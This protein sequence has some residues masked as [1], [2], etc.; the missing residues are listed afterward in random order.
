MG[1]DKKRVL[2]VGGLIVLL[3]G[4]GF[5]GAL[6]YWRYTQMKPAETGVDSGL[7]T[8]RANRE[9]NFRVESKIPGITATLGSNGQAW[10]KEKMAEINYPADKSFVVLQNGQLTSV[11]PETVAFVFEPIDTLDKATREKTLYERTTSVGETVA[12]MQS[13]LR[14]EEAIYTIYLDTELLGIDNIEIAASFSNR[15]LRVIFAGNKQAPTR[16]Q[17]DAMWQKVRE[18]QEWPIEVRISQKTSFIVPKLWELILNKLTPEVYAQS[19]TGVIEC[20][21]YVN[22]CSCPNGS[23]CGTSGDSCPSG[24]TCSCGWGCVAGSPATP[25]EVCPDFTTESTCTDAH[26]SACNGQCAF[27]DSCSWGSGTVPPPGTGG[28]CESATAPA[29]AASCPPGQASLHI[30]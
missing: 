12:G 17:L 28:S 22:T 21:T 20:G 6:G 7:E 3:F 15:I 2:L 25:T 8:R 30:G 13:E 29:C 9:I 18:K 26:D 14:G 19:C 1:M 4:L 10:I 5:F 16:E 23:G 24:G 27:V 11:Y